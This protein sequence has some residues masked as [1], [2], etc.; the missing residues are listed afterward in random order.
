MNWP[1]V[2]RVE[3]RAR[4]M[5]DMMRRLGVDASTLARVDAGDAY[6]E[7]R[8][9]CLDCASCDECLRWLMTSDTGSAIPEFCP[10]LDLF[11]PCR[12]EPPE[13]SNDNTA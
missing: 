1:Q 4:R 6:L 9:R 10:N 2:R 11:L 7:A 8:T 3:Q 5:N 13:A 12:S